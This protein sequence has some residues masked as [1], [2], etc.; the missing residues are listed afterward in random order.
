MALPFSLSEY[1]DGIT[2]ESH[3][4]PARR[5]HVNTTKRKICETC[6]GINAEDLIH[7]PHYKHV[8]SFLALDQGC[9]L[10]SRFEKMF[11]LRDGQLMLGISWR[12]NDGIAADAYIKVMVEPRLKAFGSSKSKII[13]V[14]AQNNHGKKPIFSSWLAPAST[15]ST[16]TIEP[17]TLILGS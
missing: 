17:Y 16:A 7:P 6:L 9:F 3:R 12:P 11:G 4:P 1:F 13:L 14:T 2:G 15:Y 5:I 8:S 10:C